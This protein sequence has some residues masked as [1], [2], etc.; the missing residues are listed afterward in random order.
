MISPH[1]NQQLFS[2]YY[3]NVTLE[4]REDWMSLIGDYEV[5][6]VRK[7]ITALFKR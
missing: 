4:H 5:E 2:D 7:K 6:V 3:L 1:H